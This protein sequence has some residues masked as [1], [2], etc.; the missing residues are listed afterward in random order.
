MI[1]SYLEQLINGHQEKTKY[2]YMIKSKYINRDG[3]WFFFDLE[4][5]HEDRPHRVIWVHTY[6]TAFKFPSERAVEEFHAEFIAPRPTSIIR[7]ENR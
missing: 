7:M 3:E 4:E 2:W 5:F 1:G 6:T